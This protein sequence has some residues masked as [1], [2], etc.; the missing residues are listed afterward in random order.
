MPLSASKRENGTCEQWR[1][2]ERRCGTGRLVVAHAS[3]A[4]TSGTANELELKMLALSAQAR[5]L[6][7]TRIRFDDDDH[8]LTHEEVVLPLNRLPGLSANAVDIPDII[9]L[10]QLYGL[11]LGH[12]RERVSIVQATAGIAKLF[13]IAKGSDVVKL[14]RV[15]ETADGKPIEWR[16]ALAYFE[17]KRS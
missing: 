7:V 9:D 17:T 5:V 15:V 14:D 16:V 1:L 11:T 13:R 3:I 6:R 4:Q 10:A 8:P 12:A 2:T